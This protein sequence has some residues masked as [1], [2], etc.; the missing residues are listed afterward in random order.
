VDVAETIEQVA[1]DSY[2]RLLA[3]LAAPTGD[4]AAAEDALSD[5]F[6]RALTSW[7][8][9]MPTHPE[10][11]LLTV[12]RNR[13]K[14]LYK[15]AAHKNVEIPDAAATLD[16]IDLDAIPDRRLALLFTCAHPA[17]DPGIRTPLMLQT[18]LGFDAAQVARAF[19]IPEPA[20]AQRLVR[21]KRKIKN[22]R[23]RFAVPERSE[24]ASRLPPVLEAIYGAYAI[25]QRDG[26]AMYLAITL[27][28]LLDEPEVLGLAALICLS[29]SRPH[30][31]A[32][33]PLDQQD[34]SSWSTEL[35]ARGE[36]F[37]TR[38]SSFNEIGRFQ[39]EAAI[40]SA[41]ADRARTGRTDWAAIRTL[42]AALVQV[43]PT[44]GAQVGLALATAQVDGLERGLAALHSIE[45]AAGFQPWWAAKAHLLEQNGD[46]EAAS[47]ARLK[48]IELTTDPRE[49]AWL[50]AR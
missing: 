32:Y 24:M 42:Y 39:L 43:A 6:E 4:I 15:S 50:T 8:T 21:A 7:E 1:R 46:A 29:S 36:A 31:G 48:A 38:A 26:E 28:E 34:P 20:M 18:V 33:V 3:I 25:T 37:L 2:G 27:T 41:H 14:D 12:A 10:G 16:A 40:Q 17:I 47:S 35:I 5:A 19:A 23:I 49:R 13:L 45:G 11:W 22:A 9:T 30:G 44:L